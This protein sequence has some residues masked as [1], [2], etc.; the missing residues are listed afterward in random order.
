MNADELKKNAV[1]S[2]Y[3]VHDLNVDPKLPYED[4]SFDVITNAVSVDYL[5][6]PFEVFQ[7]IH[8]VLKP[9]GLAIMSFSNRC[10]PTKGELCSIHNS[11]R[12]PHGGWFCTHVTCSWTRC[13]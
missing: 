5:S 3:T 6:K 4:A 1:L 13:A 2:D 12:H 11:F 7:E 10:F 9:G 8:R